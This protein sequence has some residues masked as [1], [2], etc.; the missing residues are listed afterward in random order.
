MAL[1]RCV[2]VSEQY[3]TGAVLFCASRVLYIL[4]WIYLL[5]SG[6]TLVHLF[7]PRRRRRRA[8]SEIVPLMVEIQVPA[9]SLESGQVLTV[10]LKA[11]KPVRKRPVFPPEILAMIFCMLCRSGPHFSLSKLYADR[12]SL[13]HSSSAFRSIV[14]TRAV[15][16][17][18]VLVDPLMAFDQL[19]ACLDKV[20]HTVFD[21]QVEL[22]D[23]DAFPRR[24]GFASIHGFVTDVMGI[25]GPSFDRCVTLDVSAHSTA[26]VTHVL[27]TLSVW[28][29]T[30]LSTMTFTYPL[31][32]Y[33]DY[34]PDE[35]NDVQFSIVPIFGVL[36]PPAKVMSLTTAD[37]GVATVA[38]TSSI[39]TSVI[40]TCPDFRLPNW[41]ELMSLL[42]YSDQLE[43]L[44]IDNFEC[45]HLP[46][47]L[48]I[49]PPMAS[50]HTLELAFRG[51]RRMGALASRLVLPRL[52][53]L[54]LVLESRMDIELA[55]ECRGIL[56]TVRELVFVGGCTN[57]H[58]L[59]QIFRLLF[60]V[61]DLDFSDASLSVWNEFASASNIR[62]SNEDVV[63]RFACPQ[64]LHLRV[65]SMDLMRVKGVLE[66]R[67][68][69]G[70]D[71]ISTVTMPT[72]E[73]ASLDP[74][75]LFWFRSHSVDLSFK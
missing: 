75:V 70:Y 62:G 11:S 4:V 48:S 33:L 28:M 35:F 58:G 29:P 14:D 41:T 47:Y 27:E 31:H 54:K 1:S 20:A 7:L 25:V 10:F 44:V 57:P 17:S 6:P 68:V 73:G 39:D 38:Y 59:E 2:C 21:L 43:T 23:V 69:S 15:F 3:S 5:L 46:R 36:F 22:A 65:A 51:R 71:N 26:M 67:L 64:L 32:D 66:S 74:D 16:W 18:R 9:C 72:L 24:P 34:D 42:S 60:R 19:R 45:S 37:L 61:R 63:N 50:V 53:T 13:M 12:R 49:P 30:S 52:V 56:S 8:R 40:I 55:A